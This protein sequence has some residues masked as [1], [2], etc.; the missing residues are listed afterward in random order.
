MF[1]IFLF[2]HNSMR[3]ILLIAEKPEI[4]C[5]TIFVFQLKVMIVVNFYIL[6][7]YLQCFKNTFLL[8]K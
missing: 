4:L 5:L 3:S 1:T 8:L 6:F 2:F 7:L